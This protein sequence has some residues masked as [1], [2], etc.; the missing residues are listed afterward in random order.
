MSG[1][2]RLVCGC[3]CVND[4]LESKYDDDGDDEDEDQDDG[5]KKAAADKLSV[6]LIENSVVI[7]AKYYKSLDLCHSFD[8]LESMP[9]FS[10]DTQ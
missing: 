6:S 3:V 5:R 1:D 9:L 2:D 4:K 7:C 8:L 10:K